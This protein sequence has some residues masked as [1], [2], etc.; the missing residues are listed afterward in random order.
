M[1]TKTKKTVTVSPQYAAAAAVATHYGFTSMPDVVIEKEQLQK[2]RPFADSQS[3]FA[4]YLEE[5]IAIMQAYMEKRMI[6]LQQPVMVY[7]EG[8]LKGNPRMKRGIKDRTFNLEII[9]NSRPIAE[10][11]I[12]ETAFVI[13]RERYEKE[14]LLVELNSIGDKEFDHAIYPR[15]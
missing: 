9:G 10:A 11:M 7:Y 6:H 8:P 5:K 15:A 13:A 12:I 3:K 14:D 1:P 2:A 4:G